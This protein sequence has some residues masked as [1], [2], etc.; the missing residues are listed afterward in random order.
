[1]RNENKNRE[2]EIIYIYNYPRAVVFNA[3]TNADFL[4]E[5]FALNGCIIDYKKLDIKEGGSYHS[6]IHNPEFGDCWCIGVYKVVKKPELIVYTAINADE[7][8]NPI[9]PVSI[10]MDPDWPG[11]TEVRVTFTEDGGKT[12]VKL[13]QNV[14]ES[15]AK[16]TGAHP[17][18]VQMLE[19]L[20][21]QLSIK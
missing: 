16:R 18:W 7:E 20:D 10:G 21:K 1:M 9:D 17:S 14:P 13:T 15:V 3:W 8:G 19:R 2:V 12:V 11:E 4:K 6:C 5:W